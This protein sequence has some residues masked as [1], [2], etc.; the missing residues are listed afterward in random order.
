MGKMLRSWALVPSRSAS[1][2]PAALKAARGPPPGQ[3]S[4]R[5]VPARAP[6]GAPGVPRAGPPAAAHRARGRARGPGRLRIELGLRRRAAAAARAATAARATPCRPGL[7]NPDYT[8]TWNPGILAD[9]PTGKPLGADGLPVRTTIV[10]QRAGAERRR[11]LGDP[12]RARRLQGQEPGRRAR[13][14]ARTRVSATI[15]VPSGVVLR[16]AGSGRRHGHGHRQHQRRPRPRHRHACRTPSATTAAASTP[17]RSRSSRRTRRRRRRRSPS[18]ARPGFAA[19]D[20]AL[21]DQLDDSRGERGRL[22]DH[23]QARRQ[24]R[25]RASASRSRRSPATRSP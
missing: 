9:T 16:G 15:N 11:D 6:A 18:R 2:W 20:L 14:R 3:G 8:T 12:E 22:H 7:L 24:L 5:G 17:R 19:G 13:R 23:L 25:R 1:S 21:V 10:R 4:R